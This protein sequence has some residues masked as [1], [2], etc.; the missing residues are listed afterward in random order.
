MK[1]HLKTLFLFGLLIAFVSCDP[2]EW[3]D[4]IEDVT[5]AYSPIYMTRTQL[6]SS[7]AYLE[8]EDFINPGKIYYKGDY[9]YVTEKYKGIHI[10]DNRNISNPVKSGFIRIPGCVDLAIKNNILY[11]DNAVD[12]VAI[13]LNS[14]PELVVTER[15]KGTFPDLIP[16]D[17]N[18]MPEEYETENRPDNMII[19]E[20]VLA[21]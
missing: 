14:L 4:G 10:I 8:S 5:T 17:A 11:A 2:W 7:I 9:I 6:E 20:W 18:M 21:E 19:V 3:E 13:D 1:T 12:L 16:P 15:V